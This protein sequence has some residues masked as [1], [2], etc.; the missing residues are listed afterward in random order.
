MRVLVL[1]AGVIGIA[2]AYYLKQN[3]IEVT[4]I[5]ADS[6]A[7]MEC[8]YSNGAQLSYS[9]CEPLNTWGNLRLALS[10]LGKKDA[11]LL[12]R[13]SLDPELIKWLAKFMWN[14]QNSKKTTCQAAILKLSYYSKLMMH[15]LRKRNKFDFSFD[16][17]GIIHAY[18]DYKS[19]MSDKAI[20]EYVAKNTGMRHQLMNHQEAINHSPCIER[21]AKRSHS[22]I[23]TPD[24]ET[25]DVHAFTQAL[26]KQLKHEKC[27]FMYDT[28]V[29]NLV[30]ENGKVIGVE[31]NRGF[32]VA[33]AVVVCL[34]AYSQELLSSIGVKTAIYPMKGYSITAKLNRLS[35]LKGSIYDHQNRTVYTRIGNRFRI[36]GTA[37][38]NGYNHDINHD[39][40]AVMLMRAK[41]DFD[42]FVNFKKSEPWA[43]L[44]PQSASS[45]PIIGRVRANNLYINS[46]H[47]TLGWTQ[48]LGS[49]R[50]IA[51]LI[52]GKKPEISLSIFNGRD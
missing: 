34:G 3:G 16:N 31:T 52:A 17:K 8:S 26:S 1:G 51:D 14:C 18:P 48:A 36:A 10:W 29:D 20:F 19:F 47:G 7:A 46:G 33:D 40:I 28:D 21:I 9:Y 32:L 25:G 45:V 23:W 35:D 38:F 27:K 11:P 43:C 37:E 13:P 24:D 12:I 44:R 30:L 41:D 50:L 4:I 49:G 22:I 42:D 2:T 6:E 5:E 15:E 39:R